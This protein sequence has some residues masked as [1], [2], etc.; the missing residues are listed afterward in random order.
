MGRNQCLL[1]RAT[2]REQGEDRNRQ[3]T[4]GWLPA[5]RAPSRA[6]AANARDASVAAH[7][8]RRPPTTRPPGWCSPAHRSTDAP[9]ST[10]VDPVWLERASS[11]RSRMMRRPIVRTIGQPPSVVPAVSAAPHAS[12]AQTGEARCEVSPAGEGAARPRF[13]STSVHRSLHGSMRDRPTSSTARRAPALSHESWRG[14]CDTPR[15]SV[16]DQA[17]QKPDDGCQRHHNHHAQHTDRLDPVEPAP[18]HRTRTTLSES[19]ADQPAQQCV[20]GT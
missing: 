3:P 12:S 17:R 1:K 8:R 7:P 14:A 13:R 2:S 9:K 16:R 11:G 5:R 19:C 4:R 15:P 18:V 6:R 20:T 10:A